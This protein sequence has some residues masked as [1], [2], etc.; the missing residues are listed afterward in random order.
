MSGFLVQN[1]NNHINCIVVS[2][3]TIYLRLS[4]LVT[5]AQTMAPSVRKGGLTFSDLVP[6]HF[7]RG[8]GS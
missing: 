6:F 3:V 7:D 2:T 5:Q 1:F 4:I 8:K